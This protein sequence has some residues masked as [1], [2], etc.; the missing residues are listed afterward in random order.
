MTRAED[1]WVVERTAVTFGAAGGG[2]GTTGV[3]L[4]E[5]PASFIA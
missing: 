5:I 4:A 1:C 3:E 2:F